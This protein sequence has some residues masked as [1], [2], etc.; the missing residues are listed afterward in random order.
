M[1]VLVAPLDWGLGHATR[2]IP[3]I[4]ELLLQGDE[5]LI[6]A[7]GNTRQLLKKEFPELKFISLRGYRINY[8]SILPMSLSMAL[9]SPKI[10]LRIFREHQELKKIIREHSID[11]IISDNRYGLWNKKI[12]SVFI[13]HQV[14]IKCPP[15]LKFLEPLLYRI[16]KYFISKYDNCWIPDDEKNLSGDLSN[17][18]TLPPNAK[19]IGTLSR[20][21]KEKI[22]STEKKY[23]LL[24]I[25]SGPEPHRNAF[26]KLLIK[27]LSN[28]DLKALIVC[29]K[30]GEQFETQINNR[31]TII[32][33][34]ESKKLLE[35]VAVSEK[36]ICRAGYSGIMDLVAVKKDAV[37]V[38]TPGQTEQIY[39]ARHLKERKIFYSTDQKNFNLIDSLNESKKYSVKNLAEVADVLPQI[40]A[41]WRKKITEP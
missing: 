6:A 17:Q 33:H 7:D 12:Q 18:Y 16:N 23:D 31:I 20:W 4:Q 26:E 34:L 37:L 32:S 14:M 30:P 38:P 9:Q 24:C 27:Q 39:L 36:V 1:K 40:I 15:L 35:A 3:I 2:C 10:L 41:G 5:V 21:K 28:S 11:A 19:F 22:I 8:S 29:G 13:T 25:I